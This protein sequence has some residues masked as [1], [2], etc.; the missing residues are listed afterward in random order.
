[1]SLGTGQHPWAGPLLCPISA[2]RAGTVGIY[3]GPSAGLEAGAAWAV[4]A[5][6]GGEAGLGE[7]AAG[8]WAEAG[9]SGVA[10]WLVHTG[11]CSMG[12]LMRRTEKDNRSKGS[13]DPLRPPDPASSPLCVKVAVLGRGGLNR[14]HHGHSTEASSGCVLWG[15]GQRSAS[16]LG[17]TAQTPE[18]YPPCGR[19]FLSQNVQ[20]YLVFFL[21][22][23][24]CNEEVGWITH[25]VLSVLFSSCFHLSPLRW[26]M[27]C[28]DPGEG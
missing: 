3:L 14:K 9:S 4:A 6:R 13:L 17:G 18:E 19:Y 27:H 26:G 21:S 7:A 2:V 10:A 20:T 5:A 16:S 11:A 22:R 12:V 15:Q 25:Q 24:P 1:M 8:S 23:T 28:M